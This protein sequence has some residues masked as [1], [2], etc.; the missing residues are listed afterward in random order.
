MSVRVVP[1]TAEMLAVGLPAKEESG[2]WLHADPSHP[3]F[4]ALVRAGHE[5]VAIPQDG[6]IASGALLVPATSATP[7]GT[8]TYVVDRLLGPGGCPWD[9]AQTHESLKKHLLSET[10]EVIDAID[11]GDLDALKE[12]LGDLLLQPLMHSQMERLAGTFSIDEVAE[13]ITAKLVRR[14]PHVFG[15]TT[16]ADADAV[17]KNWDAIK[18]QEKQGA[19]SVL[20]SIPRSTPALLRAYEVSVRA[21]R[22]GFEWPDL[23]S[24]FEK[25][26]EEEVELK[27]AV[28]M[29]NPDHVTAELGD[30]LFSLVNIARWLKVEPEDALRSM[31]DRFVQRFELM[32][33][34]TDVP[35]DSLSPDQWES[36]WNQAKQQ[37]SPD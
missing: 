23:E 19:R 11:S 7:F 30:M 2:P 6:I 13:A 29:G 34:L 36:L 4:D 27:E 33:S 20:G 3:S 21:A 26:R 17:L 1:L 25:L 15:D 16:A 37:L 9:Q 22:A 10:Y 14:H 28:S 32:E 12:E 8:L 18:A 24:V 5:V 31:V 35:L